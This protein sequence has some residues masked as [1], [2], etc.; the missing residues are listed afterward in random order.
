MGRTTY[1]TFDIVG[2]FYEITRDGY[3]KCPFHGDKDPSM[4]VYD[5]GLHCFGCE[6]SGSA[7]WF[8]EQLE[9]PMLGKV[10]WT[11]AQALQWLE[12]NGFVGTTKPDVEQRP[13]R[14]K[15]NWRNIDI[16]Q[17]VIDCHEMLMSPTGER[18]RE[19]L[20][21]RGIDDETMEAFLLGA[22]ENA[23]VIPFW[24]G[25]PGKSKIRNLQY[26]FLSG[27]VRYK[28][29]RILSAPALIGRWQKGW[30]TQTL[31]VFF[32][33]FDAILAMQDGLHAVSPSGATVLLDEEL[34]LEAFEGMQFGTVIVVP[35][36]SPSEYKHANKMVEILRK[37]FAN[38][39][40]VT[41]PQDWEGKDYTDWRMDGKSVDDFLKMIVPYDEKEFFY[42]CDKLVGPGFTFEQRVRLFT[43]VMARFHCTMN[44]IIVELA[45]IDKRYN[46]LIKPGVTAYQ[47]YLMWFEEINDGSS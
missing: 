31:F 23:V 35:D 6:W 11:K 14:P 20:H 34:C 32:G 19:Y 29:L 30:L 16:L 1:P 42:A 45:L 7:L 9:D 26:R 2:K 25:I 36:N 21:S 38:V 18:Q 40:L 15:P 12:D 3:I 13:P 27:P 10:K 43:E 41:F 44:D 39:K 28:S 37:R 22:Q 33:T 5:N 24:D 8:L 46:T 4:R 47:L 17:S